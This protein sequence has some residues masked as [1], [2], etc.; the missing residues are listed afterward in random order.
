MSIN[1]KGKSQIISNPIR[2]W[3][4]TVDASEIPNRHLGGGVK[5]L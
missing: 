4:S 5:T 3:E 1:E 2:F